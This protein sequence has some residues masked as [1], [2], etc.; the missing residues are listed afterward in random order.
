MK[1]KESIKILI[2]VGVMVTVLLALGAFFSYAYFAGDKTVTNTLPLSVEI[3]EGVS[4]TLT[5]TG[6]D[7]ITVSVLGSSMLNDSIGSVAG[8]GNTAISLELESNMAVTCSYEIAWQWNTSSPNQYTKS[9]GA[10]KEFTVSGTDGTQSLAETQISNY[11][12]S[13]TLGSY[14][15]ET[16]GSAAVNKTWNFTANFYNLNL[17]QDAHAGAIYK[18]KLVVQNAECAK[19][20]ASLSDTVIALADGTDRTALGDGSVFK[21]EHETFEATAGGTVDA[22]YRYEGK[23]PD[24]YVYYN[25]EL[26]RIIGVFDGANIGLEPGKKYTQIIRNAK[27]SSNMIWDWEDADG[28]GTKDSGEYLNDWK[29]ATLNTTLNTDY[30]NQTGAYTSTSTD[31]GLSSTAK[32]MIAKYNENYSTWYLKGTGSYTSLSSPGWYEVERLTGTGGNSGAYATET[33]AAIGLMYPSDYG[34]AMY[35]GASETT[36]LNGSYPVYDYNDCEQ[37]DWLYLSSTYQWTITP[38]S[39]NSG[40]AFYVSSAGRVYGNSVDGTRAVRPVLYLESSVGI[41]DGSGTSG[42]PYILK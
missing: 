28:D 40:Y 33:Q 39:S 38:S 35:G 5:A 32:G 42:D 34:Y 36:C 4:A 30:L 11:A 19:P 22:G 27:F 1:N 20:A 13:L 18:G 31:K 26:W 37:Y 7:D 2:L 10:S 14:Q 16:D 25:D 23:N 15:I 12:T 8:T 21:V 29:N 24:N 17:N 9:T 3:E 6:S 41:D